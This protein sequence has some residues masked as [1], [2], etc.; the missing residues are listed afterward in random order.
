MG[1]DELY[2]RPALLV[3]RPLTIYYTPIFLRVCYKFVTLHYE[4]QAFSPAKFNGDQTGAELLN[5]LLSR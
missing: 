3:S 1:N 5:V 2:K 4:L